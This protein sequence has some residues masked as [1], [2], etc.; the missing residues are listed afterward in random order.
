MLQQTRVDTVIPFYERFLQKFPA[1]G[2]LAEADGQD[3]L[4][5]WEGLG[6]YSRARNLHAAAREVV[7]QYGG[8]LPRTSEKLSALKGFGPYTSRAV[9]SIAFNEPSAVVD[10][11]VRRVISRL[12]ATTEPVDSLAQELMDVDS[13]ADW[14]QAMME[15]GATVCLPRHPKCPDC[16]IRTFCKAFQKGT[17][18]KY[19]ARPR[20]TDVPVVHAITLV[21]RNGPRV[22]VRKRP[23]S[24]L[25]GGLWE[26]P[27]FENRRTRS[28]ES[29]K[30][31]LKTT[32]G[33]TP[34]RPKLI[35]S[36]EHELSHRTI[37]AK[38]YEAVDHLSG[39]SVGGEWL[40][41]RELRKKP[42]SRFQSRIAELTF[43]NETRLV[44]RS[45]SPEI[46]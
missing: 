43:L 25:W 10:G 19:P 21:V 44:V 13:P 18:A 23:A 37:R 15:L 27:T 11:N 4:K 33:I 6:Y 34:Q 26:F 20:K 31:E 1:L 42:L 9:A 39:S 45:Q 29:V 28:L 7:E 3:V 35:G 17:V 16:P 12:Y 24:G 40:N 32:H 46:R 14:N 30:K 41:V 36:L 2:A 5:K 38:V 22:F 8:N